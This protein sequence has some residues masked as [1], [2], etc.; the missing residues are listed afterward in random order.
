MSLID[1]QTGKE[2]IERYKSNRTLIL[3]GQYSP[4]ILTLSE[5]FERA[6]FDSLL[7]QQGC[8]K[9]RMFLGMDAEL[10]IRA[11]FVGVDANGTDM[12]EAGQEVIAE[13]GV[14]CPEVCPEPSPINP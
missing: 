4:D 5:T 6:D 12:L 9:I 14:R 3:L 7:K 2:M 11:V 8:Q 10:N 1:L 13:N